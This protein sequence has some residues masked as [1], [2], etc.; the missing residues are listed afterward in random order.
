MGY[1]WKYYLEDLEARQRGGA[2]GRNVA[3][4]FGFRMSTIER[5]Q[6]RNFVKNLLLNYRKQDSTQNAVI[7]DLVKAHGEYCLQQPESSAA[8][9]RHNTMV[10][11]Y[12]LEIALHNR[13]VAVKMGI[14]KSAVCKNIAQAVEEMTILCF[15][16]PAVPG[17]PVTWKE[18]IKSLIRNYPL[19][20]RAVRCS[21]PLEC[22]T[23]QQER[24]KCLKITGKAIS[25]F[26]R[27]IHMYEEFAGGIR[28]PDEQRRPL[29]EL[30]ARYLDKQMAI[31]DVASLFQVSE[32][33]VYADIKKMQERF[34]KMFEITEGKWQKNLK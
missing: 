27:A 20:K 31:V 34:A 26:E 7:T 24:E 16:L 21:R 4:V 9:M 10:Y 25:G 17:M 18:G 6:A 22:K 30:K 15:G 11:R 8:K 12:M 14:S 33:C 5:K 29:E 13:A 1:D 2:K 3:Q 19:L 32:K 28:F 23:W